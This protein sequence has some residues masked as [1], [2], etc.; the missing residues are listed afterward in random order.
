MFEPAISAGTFVSQLIAGLSAEAPVEAAADAAGAESFAQM[1]CGQ[2]TLSEVLGRLREL[3]PEEA[4]AQVEALLSGGKGLPPAA[5]VAGQT[6]SDMLLTE[7]QLEP[8]FAS[9][10][11]VCP[12]IPAQHPSA[13]ERNLQPAPRLLQSNRNSGQPLAFLMRGGAA[14]QDLPLPPPGQQAAPLQAGAPVIMEASIIPSGDALAG[15]L[16]AGLPQL[17]KQ[18][19]SANE[20][21]PLAAAHVSAL[22]GGMGLAMT[23]SPL[24]ARPVLSASADMNTPLGDAKWS[25]SL[26]DRVLWM[27]GQ[28]QQSASIKITPPDMGTIDIKVSVQNDQVNV[29]FTAQHG[30]VKE[31]LEA[32]IPRLREMF[33]ENNLQL[34]NVDVGQQGDR[35]ARPQAEGSD[36]GSADGPGGVSFAATDADGEGMQPPGT[37]GHRS[38]SLL[39]DYA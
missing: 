30:A 5:D 23:E 7:E 34:V 26:G 36:G 33:G 29:G 4:F 28:S 25:Q 32:A 11:L 21:V 19:A 24:L 8:L 13:A 27:I 37:R 12:E 22:S 17:L 39:D 35:G 14:P 2:E 1:L 10:G 15:T 18:A 9:L 3:L 38:D 6:L 31:A 20:T 16:G